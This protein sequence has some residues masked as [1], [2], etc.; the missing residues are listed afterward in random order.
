MREKEMKNPSP[1]YRQTEI[2]M[3]SQR[4]YALTLRILLSPLAIT[5]GSFSSWQR[6]AINL[7]LLSCDS[8]ATYC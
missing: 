7:D 8:A 1:F 5:A 3:P 2:S 4:I 6:R